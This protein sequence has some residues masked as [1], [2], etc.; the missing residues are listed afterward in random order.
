MPDVLDVVEA[1]ALSVPETIETGARAQ[2]AHGEVHV[3]VLGDQIAGRHAHVVAGQGF[4]P[5]P[6]TRLEETLVLAVWLAVVLAAETMWCWP[7]AE[8][9]A[10]VSC[11]AMTLTDPVEAT[12][13]MPPAMRFEPAMV[14]LP[15]GRTSPRRRRS[16]PPRR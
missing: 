13:V 8:D 5:C 6:P 16:N 3:A 1:E 15:L 12:V 11:V 14:T 10:W 9:E 2:Q 4:T 7:E